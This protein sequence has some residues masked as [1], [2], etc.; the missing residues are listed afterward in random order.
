MNE[1][2]VKRLMGATAGV[3]IGLAI[4]VYVNQVTGYDITLLTFVISVPIA[5]VL[6]RL[7]GGPISEAMGR[8]ERG[9][10]RYLKLVILT[11]GIVAAFA[12]GWLTGDLVNGLGL[13][14]M[15]VAVAGPRLGV[16]FDERMGRTYDKA[17]TIAFAVFSLAVGYVA[18]YQRA[19]YPEL[20]NIDSFLMV[21]WISWASLLVSWGYYYFMGGE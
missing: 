13:G 5:A 8:D 18:F 21:I 9:S 15:Y 19:L 20:V 12:F 16:I 10:T 1:K 6:S 17:S 4:A 3:I 11:I 7:Y 2:V 14:F